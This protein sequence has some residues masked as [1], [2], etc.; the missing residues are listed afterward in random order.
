MICDFSGRH[1]LS[2]SKRQHTAPPSHRMSEPRPCPHLERCGHTRPFSRACQNTHRAHRR[3]TPTPPVLKAR[4]DLRA[5]TPR[6]QK[7]RCL[8]DYVLDFHRMNRIKRMMASFQITCPCPLVVP[9][10]SVYGE[11]EAES[12]I[13]W[14]HGDCAPCPPHTT[15][16]AVFRIRRLDTAGVTDVPPRSP[17]E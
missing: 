16:R 4:L 9:R 7:A 12:R 5:D 15:G 14:G 11:R 3:P 10:P 2:R 1:P 6:Q 13:G 17:T 8:D